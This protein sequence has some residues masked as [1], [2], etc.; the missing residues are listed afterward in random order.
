MCILRF[1]R[2]FAHLNLMI[3]QNIRFDSVPVVLPQNIVPYNIFSF[4]F[5][6]SD[7]NRNPDHN[8]NQ[9]VCC[10]AG[11]RWAKSMG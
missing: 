11:R 9:V 7:F 1:V 10:G 2:I 3:Y 5:G 4:I 8:P 6:P